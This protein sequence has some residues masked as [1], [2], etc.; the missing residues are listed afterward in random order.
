MKTLKRNWSLYALI[1][2][3]GLAVSSCC[4]NHWE[5]WPTNPAASG[6]GTFFLT[7]GT[8]YK[9]TMVNGK[10]NMYFVTGSASNIV[11]KLNIL[12]N[13]KNGNLVPATAF[14]NDS[15]EVRSI[16]VNGVT[17]VVH[18]NPTTGK[19]DVTVING[20]TQQLFANVMNNPAVPA[21]TPTGDPI[22]DNTSL[23]MGNLSAILPAITL[24]NQ[25]IQ[26][27]GGELSGPTANVPQYVSWLSEDLDSYANSGST[28]TEVTNDEFQDVLDEIGKDVP[29]LD[30]WSD[31]SYTD[32]ENT[33]NNDTR[34]ADQQADKNTK[35]GEGAI[36]S[37]NGKLKATLTWHYGA[38]IDLHVFEPGFT[39]NMTYYSS[40]GQGHIY[41][42]QPRNTFTDGYLDFDNTVGYFINS[43]NTEDRDLNRSAIENI[44]W[45]TVSDGVYYIYLHYYGSRG[46]EWCDYVTE[47][48]CTVGLF[49]NGIGYTKTVQ[50][51]AEYNS[52]MLYIGKVT[53]PAG[54]IDLTSPEPSTPTMQ[55]IKRCVGFLPMK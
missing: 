31:M 48:P 22:R 53:F 35:D 16:T 14:F 23:A 4:K 51:T 34:D 37:G 44:Y 21:I 12:L 9:I 40:E 38:D 43:N 54:T 7:K 39:N 28:V 1:M 15:E 50:M 32:M 27:G 19:V 20:T 29:G 11:S 41:Y 45:D 36:V 26:T 6:T 55:M 17:Y 52:R 47:G 18:K 46:D 10:G 49:V 3:C 30:Q 24:V 13:D 25:I 2:L 33:V 42:A 8:T 5:T